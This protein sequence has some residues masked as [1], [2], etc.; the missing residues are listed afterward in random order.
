MFTPWNLYPA[1]NVDTNGHI[2]VEYFN[3]LTPDGTIPLGPA[4][5]NEICPK[6]C[7]SPSIPVVQLWQNFC[8]LS[9]AIPLGCYCSKKRFS[10]SSTNTA[11]VELFYVYLCGATREI[12]RGLKLST[13]KGDVVSE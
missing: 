12:L 1:R 3:L 10:K 5:W 2:E 7:L 4:L 11:L 9:C 8:N 13:V 6:K